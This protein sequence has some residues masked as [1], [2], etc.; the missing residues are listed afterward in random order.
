MIRC[1]CRPGPR[2]GSCPHLVYDVVGG[3]VSRNMVRHVNKK[4]GRVTKT[5]STRRKGRAK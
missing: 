2:L 4:N 3:L 5:G 1:L